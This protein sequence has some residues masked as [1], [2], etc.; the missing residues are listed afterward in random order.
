MDDSKLMQKEMII[1]TKEEM[2]IETKEEMETRT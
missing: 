2:I 1:K